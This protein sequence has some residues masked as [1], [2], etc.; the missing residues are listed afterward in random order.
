MIGV[1]QAVRLGVLGLSAQPTT[2]I[3]GGL[4]ELLPIAIPAS[5]GFI[6]ATA[7]RMP[8]DQSLIW[9]TSSKSSLIASF[10]W[11]TSARQ[12]DVWNGNISGSGTR[13]YSS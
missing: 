3:L 5:V 12:H 8:P 10:E 9:N 11:S 7:G 1:G 4:L 2:L 6:T 13:A